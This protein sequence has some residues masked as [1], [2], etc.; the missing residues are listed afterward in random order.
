MPDVPSTD[1]GP[2]LH[3]PSLTSRYA[4]PLPSAAPSRTY[5]SAYSDLLT[6]IPSNIAYTIYSPNA[7]AT[8][9]KVYG[10]ATYYDRWSSARYSN[11]VFPFRTTVSPPPVA[12][13][14]LVFLPDLY[15][16]R[17]NTYS[18]LRR[19]CLSEDI[20]WEAAGRAWQIE[21]ALQSEGRG[22]SYQ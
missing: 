15:Q 3:Q 10:D 20:V 1:A 21:G 8:E 4:P 2:V 18:C 13:S 16:P 5:A 19:H 12:T 22:T 17:L 6:L 9:G 7:S 14:E 11:T